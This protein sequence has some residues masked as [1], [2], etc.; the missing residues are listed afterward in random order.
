MSC[1]TKASFLNSH[2]PDVQ[3]LAKAQATPAGIANGA[4]SSFD[5]ELPS[6]HILKTQILPLLLAF[7]SVGAVTG[8]MLLLDREIAANLI[9]IAYLI[10][11]IFAATRWG[12]WPATLASVVA[13][14]AADFFF[15][16][17]RYSFWMDDPQ[18]VIDLLLF[19][20]VALV[21][22]NLA[23]RLR[24]ETERLRRR[25]KEMQ[26]LYEF[27]RLLAACFSVSDLISAVQKYLSR[28]LGQQAAFLVTKADGRF[29][30]RQ[31]AWVPVVVQERVTSMT[32]IIG[33]PSCAIVDEPTR[34]VWL[35]GPVYSETVV[36]GLVA[37]NIGGGSREAIE[38]KTRRVEA[39]LEEVSLTLQRLD[40][41]KAME[42]A[43]LHLQAE[44]LR[45][46][47]HGTLSHEL[48]T[49]LA[50]IRGSASVLNSMPTIRK[51]D[52]VYSL[53][54]A[55]SEEA[56][57]L[58]GFIHNLLNATK[59]TAGGLN[60]HL[61][62][63]DARDIVNAAI[64][65][66]ARRLAAH[67]IATELA[68]DLPLIKVDSGLIEEACGQLL[69]NA[70]KYSPSGSTIS[71][72]ARAE[73]GR[74]VLSITDQGVGITPDEQ[75]QLGRRSF[76]SQ[77]H[78][79]TIP[80]SGLGFWIASTFVGANGGNIEI[81]SQGQGLGTTASIALP[82]SHVKPFELTD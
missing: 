15:T 82:G 69:E 64:K 74:V 39:I 21:S 48:C 7:M 8:L 35:L 47:F 38:I 20:V 24:Q 34:D 73:Q 62:W 19:L 11:V 30:L 17:P 61:E 78:Q 26:H 3:R 44:L 67:K 33:T 52:R 46:A 22:S 43:R 60:P 77:R 50:T 42:E 28:A 66:R 25:E 45:D 40:I 59:V 27:S 12:I 32:A 79:A 57:D 41:E 36:H 68:E 5:E 18:Q 72:R 4:A 49:P 55:I 76:R 13:M 54:E 56:A 51:D 6:D 37:V 31:S 75:R 70:A 65:G 23:S 53:V 80:G 1:P 81:S 58:D 10:P 63:S 71:I 16:T 14:A 2:L 9:P 29:E